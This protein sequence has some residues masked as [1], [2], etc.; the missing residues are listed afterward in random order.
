MS[1]YVYILLCIDGSF[2]TGYTGDL[3]ARTKLHQNGKGARYTKVHKPERVAYAELFNSR[4]LAMK[5]ERE[6]KK[7]SHQQKLDLVSSQNKK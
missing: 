3:D 7:L 6:I 4:S 2:Y 1:F 5:R